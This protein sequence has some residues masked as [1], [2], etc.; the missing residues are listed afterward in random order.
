[1]NPYQGM[2]LIIPTERLQECETESMV[3][4]RNEQ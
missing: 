4:L 3:S 1:M 2:G